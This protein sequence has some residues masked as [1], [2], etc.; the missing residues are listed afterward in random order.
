MYRDRD[1]EGYR[2]RS[3]SPR[4]S[5]SRLGQESR[6]IMMDGLPVDMTEEDV[7]HPYDKKKMELPLSGFP[8]SLVARD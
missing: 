7:R 1:R 2:S 4:Y 3:R 5:R 8:P 6:E